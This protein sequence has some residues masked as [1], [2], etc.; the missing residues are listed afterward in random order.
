MRA[1]D[2]KL[3]R[4][5][6]RLKG[7]MLSIAL[8]VGS[9]IMTVITMRGS[10]ESLVD[11]QQSYYRETRFAE[12]WAPLER[13]PESVRRK[14]LALP[15]VAAVDTRVTFLATLDLPG[16]DA[17]AQGRFVSIPER[18]RPLLN[19]IRLRRGRYVAPGRN[20]E[21]I[22]SEKFAEA[23]GYAPGERL[24]AVINGRARD[25]DVVGVAISP[26]H[27]YSVPPGSL[28][29]DDERYGVLWMS[30]DVIGPAY[31]MDGAF[32]EA[33]VTLVKGADPEAV[34]ERL[35]DLLDPYGGLGAYP[36]A[37]QVSHQIL[38][39][40]LDQN[41]VMGTAIPAVFLAVAAFL[42]NL[43]LGRLISTQ[44]GEIAVLKA[45]GYRDREVGTHYLLFALA[46]VA[47]GAVLGAGAG[48]WLG[49]AYVEMYGEYF[50]FPVLEYQLSASLL[51]ISLGVSFVAAAAG[52]LGAVRRAVTLPP[53]EA[54]RPE[55]PAR[56]APGWA[57]RAGLGALLTS[58][59]RMILRNLERRPVR[60][61]LSSLGVAFSV[62]ILV[63]GLF[64]FDGVR[65]MMDLQFRE[66]QRED[67][68]VSFE[69]SLPISVRFDLGRLHGV[70]RV[71]TFRNV[72]ARLRSGHREREVGLQGIASDGR[73]RRIVTA[74]GGVHPVPADGVVLSSMLARQLRVSTGDALSVELL[75][76]RRSKDSLRVAG[77][78]DDFLGLSTYMSQESLHRLAGGAPVVSGAYLSVE[79][80]ERS[81]LEARLKNVAAVAGVA[82]PASMLETFESQLADSLF[83]G[84]GFLLGF[85]SV[86][87]VGVIYNGARISL[88]ERGRELASLRVMGFRR[89]EVAR[90]L[91]GEQAV[92]TLLAIPLGWGL[93]YVLSSA[94]AISLET[95]AYR[96][97]FVVSPRTYSMA[98]LITVI[99][100]VAS[101]WIVRRRADRLD[102]IS[103]L[104]T[105]E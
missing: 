65:F 52:A 77:V 17:P 61:L 13:A 26:E 2:R 50:E 3:I 4:E 35:D 91:L 47:A 45:F 86:I 36:R 32:N 89:G 54:M 99:V 6:W 102:L 80:Q 100:A 51:V 101:G 40:E 79:D 97:P 71:E 60:S 64:M 66:I 84:V 96:V 56:F 70:T 30:R 58:A 22:I 59:G 85:A 98:A 29:P 7:Q 53:A 68:I 28:F 92:V 18:G 43:V 44:R 37:D 95:E 9:G 39:G 5:L 8:V 20:D 76:G 10:Y 15:G 55:P 41:R 34:I 25:L 1:L 11:A 31:E 21:V 90:L 24:R 33:L 74:R 93:G 49:Q 73:L 103:V 72:P 83:I 88:S 57:E 82:S 46:A 27:T 48:V 105:R 14:I 87:S 104:K 62:A 94:V 67:L 16:L 75:E 23:R 63:I 19:D 69:K 38:E 12:V 42:L 78:V 81:A